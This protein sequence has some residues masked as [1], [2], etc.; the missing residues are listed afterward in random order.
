[1]TRHFLAPK[2][3]RS[4]ET[5]E[6]I[7]S[8][9]ESL[10]EDEGLEA[11]TIPRIAARARIAIGSVYRRFRDKDAL[12]RYVFE[13]FF[14]KASEANR[15]DLDP[16][17]WEQCNLKQILD[18]V[19]GGMVQGHRQR[20]NLL[21][22]LLMFLHEHKDDTFRRH[23]QNL[24]DES[25]ERIQNLLLSKRSEICHPKAEVATGIIILAVS[26]TLQER[27]LA[28]KSH[29][30]NRFSDQHITEELTTL[31]YAYLTTQGGAAS[32]RNRRRRQ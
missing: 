29:V 3:G 20:R 10:L 19:I 4:R 26:A 27:L 31:A 18:S 5:L 12:M 2:Q 32:L 16:P 30:L 28:A 15:I 7:L 17:K 13:G 22:G 1:M 9:T 14:I 25:M 21:R 11:A 23:A 24:M 6:R 8:A